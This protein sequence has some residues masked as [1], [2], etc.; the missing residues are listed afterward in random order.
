MNASLPH[1]AADNATIK[2]DD[3]AIEIDAS[4]VGAG[5]GLE[6]Q[7]VLSLMRANAIM[8]VCEHGV[9]DDA[10]RHRLTFFYKGRRL[11]LIV[12]DCGRLVRRS[13]IDFGDRP[14]PARMHRTG[15]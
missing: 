9:D 10:G 13:T 5:L 3:G 11:R 1:S 2:I 4:I 15:A 6:P 7:E 8:S 14:L 12:D